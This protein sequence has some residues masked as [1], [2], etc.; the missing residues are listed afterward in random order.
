MLLDSLPT[1]PSDSYLPAGLFVIF[2]VLAAGGGYWIVWI[3]AGHR[4]RRAAG[5]VAV[6]TL[7]VFALLFVGLKALLESGAPA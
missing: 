4:N 1:N 6:L 3:V 5:W 7:L 2:A